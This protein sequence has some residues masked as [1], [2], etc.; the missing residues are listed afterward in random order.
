MHNEDN[1]IKNARDAR[2][3]LQNYDRCLEETK[4]FVG[5]KRLGRTH[6]CRK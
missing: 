4:D 1:K 3:T 2:R 5:C 6:Y